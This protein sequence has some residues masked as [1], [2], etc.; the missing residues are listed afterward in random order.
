M[1]LSVSDII[2]LPE[3]RTR[4]ISGAG[5]LGK[6]VRWAHVCELAAPSEWLGDADLLMT[7]GIGIPADADA[8]RAYVENLAGAGLAGM[9]IGENMQA[10][11]NL[12]ALMER[13]DALDFAVMFTHYGVPFAAVTRAIVDAGQQEEQARR[14]AITRVYE[15]ARM[16]IQ[17][18]GLG[19]LLKRLEKD[20]QAR[21]TLLDAASLAPWRDALGGLPA[22]QRQ[23]LAARQR[24]TSGNRPVV[25]RHAL[26]AGELL[27]MA[28]PSQADCLL[29]A[30]GDGLLDYGLLHHV[31]A[32]LG[33][34]LERL[35]V[36]NERNLR[37]GSELLDDLLQQ[38]LPAHQAQQRLAAFDIGAEQACLLLGRAAGVS[39]AA[40]DEALQRQGRR[41]LIRVQGDDLIVLG[42]AESI[43]QLQAQLQA[44]LGVSNPLGHAGRSVEALR[45]AR[46]ALAHTSAAQPLV[47][48]AQAGASVP[49]LAQSLDEA[50][51]TFRN[52]LGPLADY[53]SQQNT[54][55]LHTLQVFLQHNRSW[56]A[57]A[58]QLHVHK[59]TLV[60]RMR[61]I[62]E[63]TGRSLDSTEDVA[64]LWFALRAA[65]MAGL[66]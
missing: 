30:E 11:A 63:I 59:Q 51:R 31:V 1:A 57:A 3:L 36:D 64:T 65:R 2:A 50:E 22:S 53:D 66:A 10:P 35:R 46:L 13:A 41:V 44:P 58:A 56:L 34:E 18:L 5:G 32:V 33:I 19:A 28:L 17:G 37:L 54:Q 21:L 20:V 15:S 47:T 4:V 42:A 25:Q 23:W 40:C 12:E 9:M 48:Y 26:E 52:V 43:P 14:N 38:R 27:V 49:W 61:R 6:P 39:P 29:V 60:Y 7:T 55:L 45:E 8:Q 62:E 16:S 24:D